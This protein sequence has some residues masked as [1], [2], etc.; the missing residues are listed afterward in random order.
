MNTLILSQNPQFNQTFARRALV[1]QM[2]RAAGY[3][4]TRTAGF[5]EITPMRQFTAGIA[6]KE[7]RS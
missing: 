7:G 2:L 3:A 1:E 6:R 5:I 4:T